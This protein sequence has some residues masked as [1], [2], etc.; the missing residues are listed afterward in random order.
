[1][2]LRFLGLLRDVTVALPLRWCIVTH[3]MRNRSSKPPPSKQNGLSKCRQHLP[4]PDQIGYMEAM[5]LLTILFISSQKMI[6]TIAQ[7][8][9]E[10]LVCR[11]VALRYQVSVT[12][13]C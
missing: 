5:W 10:H 8:S 12:I 6:W 9:D 11:I 4:S 1:M 13:V 2:P 3:M 7:C